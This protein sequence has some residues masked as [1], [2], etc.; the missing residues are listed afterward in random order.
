MLAYLQTTA[1]MSGYSKPLILLLLATLL[2]PFS[3]RR[4]KGYEES[5]YLRWVGDIAFNPKEDD[6]N[7]VV[8]EEEEV[9]QYHNFSLG[10]QYKG[11]KYELDR[12]FE[13]AY[14][15]KIIKGE[16]G[17]IRI[18]FIVNCR[19]ETG[20]FRVM[21][22]NENYEPKAF[23]A[24]ITKQLLRITQSLTGWKVLPNAEKPEDYYQYL[25]FKIKEGQLIEIMP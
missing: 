24:P 7:F 5:K 14:Q 21:G 4:T 8:C 19:G 15:S 9:K 2:L 13:Q 16:S 22:M 18:R 3:C 6:K 11:E 10:F 1:S 23:D 25:I 12:A 17:L 20:R